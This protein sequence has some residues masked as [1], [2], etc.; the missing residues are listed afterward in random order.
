MSSTAT[1]APPDN[2][3]GRVPACHFMAGLEDNHTREGRVDCPVTILFR[4]A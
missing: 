4:R 2:K 1:V 3:A